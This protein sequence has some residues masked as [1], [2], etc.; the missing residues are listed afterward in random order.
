MLQY[1][2]INDSLNFVCENI[3]LN[4][5]NDTLTPNITH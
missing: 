1:T 2:L 5:F 3:R 4:L